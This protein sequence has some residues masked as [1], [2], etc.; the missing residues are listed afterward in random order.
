[1][2]ESDTRRGGKND[3]GREDV[4]SSEAEGGEGRATKFCISCVSH[5]TS[6]PSSSGSSSTVAILGLR[7]G[8]FGIDL[9]NKTDNL[10]EFGAV[11]ESDVEMCSSSEAP[12]VSGG[13]LVVSSLEDEAEVTLEID[14]A[15]ECVRLRKRMGKTRVAGLRVNETIHSFSR[16]GEGKS[17]DLPARNNLVSPDTERWGG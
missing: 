6:S 16:G 12:G 14:E 4:F 2:R 1:M 7:G 17:N 5:S 3:S 15:G 8:K 13:W 9:A 10:F 11:T